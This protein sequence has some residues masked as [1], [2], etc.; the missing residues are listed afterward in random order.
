MP[1]IK[2]KPPTAQ[3]PFRLMTNARVGERSQ[4][5]ATTKERRTRQDELAATEA[6]EEEESERKKLRTGTAFEAQPVPD[7][8]A[9][10]RVQ[11]STKAPAAVDAAGDAGKSRFMR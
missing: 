8:S 9:P 5:D 1:V 2:S 10:H 4:F 6:R 3:Q 11:R 7:Y